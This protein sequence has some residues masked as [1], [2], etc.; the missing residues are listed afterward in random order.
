MREI[1][2]GPPRRFSNILIS[3]LIFFFFTGYRV[4]NEAELVRWDQNVQSFNQSTCT[5]SM[6]LSQHRF[7]LRI[8]TTTFSLLVMLI[9]SKTS[10]YLPRPSFRTNWK[11]SWFLWREKKNHC[12]TLAALHAA[13][14]VE[15]SKRSL[16]PFN[17]VRLIVPVLPGPMSVDLSVHSGPAWHGS[18]HVRQLGRDGGKILRQRR[19]VGV[20]GRW[21]GGREEEEGR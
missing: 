11:S 12:Q 5:R 10:L 21:V 17:H 7:T 15:G 8:F 4:R 3:R 9:A 19:K 14:V 6:P 1:I 13:N 2:L 20:Q 18:W 16:P